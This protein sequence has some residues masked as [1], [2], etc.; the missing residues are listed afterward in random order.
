[1]LK[2]QDLKKRFQQKAETMK[3][4]LITEHLAVR[5]KDYVL[6]YN[7]PR[8]TNNKEHVIWSYNLFTEQWKK[9]DTLG[10]EC[11]PQEI[12][13]ASAVA[14]EADVY[15]FG[16][17]VPNSLWRLTIS[18]NNDFTWFKLQNKRNFETPSERDYHSAWKYKKNMWIF[19]GFGFSITPF[20]N[21]H[22]DFRAGYNNQLLCY[23]PRHEMWTNPPCSGAVPSPRMSHA[24]TIIGHNVWLYGG[25]EFHSQRQELADFYVM[26]ME[27]YVWVQIETM[28]PNPGPRCL[29]SLTAATGNQIV[30][31]GGE[32]D[33]RVFE[34]TWIFDVDN[35]TWRTYTRETDH[36]RYQ[37]T[38]MSGGRG[39]CSS[40]VVIG[41]YSGDISLKS[42]KS[43]FHVRLEAKSL[44]QLAM[45][46]IYQHRC[47][48]QWQLLPM[49]MI[50]LLMGSLG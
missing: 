6:V 25:I 38:G 44:Q 2:K 45:Q 36:P 33:G 50:K 13:G 24:T 47:M 19:G 16:G 32:E 42:H 12:D 27:S 20:L 40:V 35:R 28:S 9:Y 11:A 21:K 3:T 8:A 7:C 18:E 4:P 15:M 46:I 39:L 31:H 14:I 34:D 41:G 26:N 5:V 48:L 49:K 10:K 17:F 43:V 22:G 1:M 29:L 23:D 37:H 30:L